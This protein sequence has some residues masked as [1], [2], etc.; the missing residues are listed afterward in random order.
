MRRL[1]RLSLAEIA[2]R[3]ADAHRDAD[4][5]QSGWQPDQRTLDGAPT[6]DAWG[7]ATYPGT[8]LPCLVGY[9]SGHPI[10]PDGPATTSPIIAWGDDW[11]RTESRFYR[12]LE[13]LRIPAAPRPSE[14]QGE[15]TPEPSSANPDEP[16]GSGFV[17]F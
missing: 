14:P 6:I 16:D 9:V 12:V 13:P 1:R 17:G 5:L 3:R 7:A 4:L 2:R 11:I 10:V 15:T 8:S